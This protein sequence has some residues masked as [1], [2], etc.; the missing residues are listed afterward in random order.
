MKR[1]ARTDALVDASLDDDGLPPAEADHA[2]TCPECARALATVRRFE[3]A[4]HSAGAELSPEPMP[5][6]IASVAGAGAE[7]MPSGR[8]IAVIGGA[9]AAAL[10]LAVFVVI[11]PW[12][13]TD[14]GGAQSGRDVG[15]VTDAWVA[16][17]RDFVTRAEPDGG[18]AAGWKPVRVERCGR[19]GIAF[20][21]A[22][23]TDGLPLYRWALGSV[24]A[25]VPRAAGEVRSVDDANVAAMR[26]ALPPC[27]L[28]VDD[29][30]APLRDIGGPHELWTV[31][32]G[33]EVVE[34]EVRLIGATLM[35]DGR[36][37]GPLGGVEVPTYLVLMDRRS[38][39]EHMVERATVSVLDGS[40]AVGRF[41]DVPVE[42]PGTQDTTEVFADPG[43]ADETLFAWIE[44]P[45]VRAVDIWVPREGQVLRYTVRSPGFVLQFDARVGPVEELTYELVDADGAIVDAGSV[46]AW[47][48]RE[49]RN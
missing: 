38:D 24:D 36:R 33:E 42:R 6:G 37:A 26:A 14:A 2:T 45:E 21:E 15:A 34:G 35:A 41:V 47:L 7:D 1:C 49:R 31:T 30:A 12:A 18:E 9:S 28:L 32:T 11:A 3:G 48:D 4:L 5:P 17:A 16:S 25:G 39:R 22:T 29:V 13:G 43:F 27:E 46:A 10:A 23:A 20:F 44:D 8:R 40:W 19:T